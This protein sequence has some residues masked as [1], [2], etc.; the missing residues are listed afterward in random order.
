MATTVSSTSTSLTIPSITSPGVGSGLDVNSIID[1]LMTIAKQPLTQL[2][3]QATD[4]NARLSAF[5]AIKGALSSLQ[6]ATNALTARTTFTAKTA[7]VADPSV[8]SAAAS[9]SALAGNYSVSVTQLASAQTVRSSED[10]ATTADTFNTGTLS[11]SV[12]GGSAVDVTID[13]SNNTLAGIAQAINN[14][15]AG[16]TASIINDGTTNRLVLT[17][18]TTGSAGQINVSATDSGSGGAHALSGLASANLVET[19]PAQD[20]I[21]TALGMTIKRS[22]NTVSDVIPG[23]TLNLTKSGTTTNPA[24]TVVTVGQDTSTT[25]DAVN[26]FVQAYNSAISLI[27]TDSQF[28]T[29]TQTAAVLGGD[30]TVRSLQMQLNDVLNTMVSGVAGGISSLADIGV[31]RKSDGTLVV[32]AAKLNAAISDPNKDVASLFAQTTSGNE[33]I[34]VKLATAL[35][36]IAG[37]GGT[38]DVRTTGLT[39]LLKANSNSQDAMNIRLTALETRYRAQFAALDSLMSSMQATSQYLTAQF[40]GKSSG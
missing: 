19:L 36:N 23:V 39:A 22:S 21:F 8:L 1:K 2:Q 32:D 20:A 3:N 7:S 14:A 35:S 30:G 26:A 24:T 15:H 18:N 34:A 28:N 13:S 31:S 10:Y 27:K 16:V 6:T 12:G 33:G 29:T 4:Y 37:A 5:G 9:A 38:I 17:S 25:S 40:S 11:I